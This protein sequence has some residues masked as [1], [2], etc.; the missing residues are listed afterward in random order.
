MMNNRQL[1]READGATRAIEDLISEIES[2][3][4][5]VY[6][7]NSEIENLQEAIEEWRE[8]TEK[9]DILIT[10]LEEQLLELKSILP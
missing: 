3:E 2:L 9:K 6:D 5:E 10:S 7:K 4:Q 8:H 1:Q